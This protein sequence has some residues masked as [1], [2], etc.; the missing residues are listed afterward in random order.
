MVKNY[1]GVT[2][3][4]APL[5]LISVTGTLI[6]HDGNIYIIGNEYSHYPG[7]IFKVVTDSVSK[8]IKYNEDNNPVVSDSDYVKIKRVYSNLRDL[9][10]H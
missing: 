4:F 1:V 9:I 10:W 8:V 7:E 3:K 5:G 2:T 6:N